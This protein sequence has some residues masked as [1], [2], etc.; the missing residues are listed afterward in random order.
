MCAELWCRI[1]PALVLEQPYCNSTLSLFWLA[2]PRQKGVLFSHYI[3]RILNTWG[4]SECMDNAHKCMKVHTCS[5]T[6]APCS[7]SLW[8][9]LQLS[10]RLHI[11]VFVLFYC[12]AVNPLHVWLRSH[13]PL[14]PLASFCSIIAGWTEGGRGGEIEKEGQQRQKRLFL[15]VFFLSKWPAGSAIKTNRSQPFLV[16]TGL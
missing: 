6:P 16:Q 12:R 4:F 9:L 10:F 11:S 5:P 2:S 7:A 13:C 15:S 1:Y 3:R 8:S 14:Q